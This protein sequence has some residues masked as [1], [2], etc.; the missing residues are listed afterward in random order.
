MKRKM[1][2]IEELEKY[3]RKQI[4]EER[5]ATEYKWRGCDLNTGADERVPL[6]EDFEQILISAER[7]ALGR[8]T[9]IVSL[10]VRYIRCLVPRLTDKTLA[11]LLRD[12]NGQKQLG[13]S[14]GMDFDEAEWVQL[15]HDIES[16]LGE[17]KA[18][19]G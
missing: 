3:W 5:K 13:K 14:Y 7:Y 10:T 8:R 15:M 17:R 16:E 12:M 4:K 9:G 6:D 1:S 18:S 2:M 19:N 11:I